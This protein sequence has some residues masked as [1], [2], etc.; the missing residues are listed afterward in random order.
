MVK[1]HYCSTPRRV[2][3]HVGSRGALLLSEGGCRWSVFAPRWRCVRVFCNV[4]VTV[5]V[6]Y[7]WQLQSN[8]RLKQDLVNEC[9]CVLLCICIARATSFRLCARDKLSCLH[10]LLEMSDECSDSYKLDGNDRGILELTVGEYR[11]GGTRVQDICWWTIQT[12]LQLT[13]RIVV[14]HVREEYTKV[15]SHVSTRYRRNRGW[16]T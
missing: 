14:V 4:V 11:V 3:F 8:M 2:R 10:K 7:A 6:R 9:C 16:F 1:I 15:Y 13:K 12:C 5:S